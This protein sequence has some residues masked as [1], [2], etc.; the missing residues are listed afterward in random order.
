MSCGAAVGDRVIYVSSNDGGPR[1]GTILAL[2]AR[3]GT[4]LWQH[5][6]D[7]AI[8]GGGMAIANGTLYVSFGSGLPPALDAA[9]A[10]ESVFVLA[11]QGIWYDAVSALAVQI[12]ADPG[13]AILRA[14]RAARGDQGGRPTLGP[15]SLP[16]V[17]LGGEAE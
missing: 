14:Q 9:D 8:I 10:E 12:D 3:D 4:Q 11:S 7:D 2:D 16:V 13:D 15:E 6:S 1:G 17:G 5:R